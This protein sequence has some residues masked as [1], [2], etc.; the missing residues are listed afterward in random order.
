MTSASLTESLQEVLALF[1][2]GGAP[3]T[4]T[5]VTEQVSC[6]HQSADERLERLVDHGWLETKTVGGSGRV[7]WRPAAADDSEEKESE[8]RQ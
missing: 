8:R 1:D 2:A 5:E 3:L 6:G 7:W 4:T